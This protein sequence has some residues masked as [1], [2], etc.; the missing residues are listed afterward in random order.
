MRARVTGVDLADTESYCRASVQFEDAS[1]TLLQQISRYLYSADPSLT[2]EQL[3][4]MGYPLPDL[5]YS[6]V[7]NYAHSP[8][9]IHE[10]MALRLD[11]V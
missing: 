8:E 5:A 10:M 6:A 4:K 9:E 7:F 11:R 1:P 3:E 2:T